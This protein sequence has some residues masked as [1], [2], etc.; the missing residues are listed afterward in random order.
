M[1]QT[2]EDADPI[3]QN[4]I[5][6]KIEEGASLSQAYLL[7]N[8]L[9]AVVASYGLLQ[10]STAVIIGAMIIAQLL[11]P[12]TGIALALVDGNQPLLRRALLAEAGGVV[13]VLTIGFLLGRLHQQITLGSEITARTAPNV[14][15]LAI[16]LAGG[17]AGAYATISPRVSAGLVGVAIAT[18]LVPPLCACGICLAHGL[19][20]ESG[21]AF[22]LFG[23]NLVA[24]QSA[25]SL[26][27]WLSGF[28]RLTA[29]GKTIVLRRFA[30]SV[31]LLT[32][33]G[34][35]LLH[36]FQT[37][38]ARETLRATARTVLRADIERSGA[39]SLTDLRVSGYGEATTLTAVVRAPWVITPQ[40][41]ARLQARLRQATGRADVLLRVRTVLTR[42]CDANQFLWTSDSDAPAGAAAP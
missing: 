13:L 31:V 37:T 26:V 39:A 32:G 10:N 38:L 1:T 23:T 4:E 34:I 19:Y 16:A 41:C 15:D 8:A 25:S 36:S 18:A 35:F 29:S 40:S 17:A 9:A 22:L 33:L 28:H 30:P 2:Q 11:G 6:Q 14:M 21:G 12:I 7:M 3:R 5:R 24:I 20:Q 42:E 27:F